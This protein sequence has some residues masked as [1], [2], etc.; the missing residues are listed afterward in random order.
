[1]YIGARSNVEQSLIGLCILYDGLGFALYGKNH[2]LLALLELFHK[3]AGAAAK[4]RERLNVFC[5][6]EHG[7]PPL[8]VVPF[9][10]LMADLAGYNLTS[11]SSD[12][13]PSLS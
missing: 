12:T 3:V 7:E 11:S 1:M 4:R 2:G 10:V 5:D 9:S 8:N 6:I 13:P